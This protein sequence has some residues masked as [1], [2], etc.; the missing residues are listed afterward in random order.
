MYLSMRYSTDIKIDTGWSL[1]G[2]SLSLL[3]RSSE[4]STRRSP[5]NNEQSSRNIDSGPEQPHDTYATSGYLT[6]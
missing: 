4:R 1:F 3:D 6:F 5:G 2:D